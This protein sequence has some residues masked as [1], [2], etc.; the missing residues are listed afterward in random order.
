MLSA[1]GPW[2]SER[3]VGETE[4]FFEYALTLDEE[5]LHEARAQTDIVF[6]EMAQLEEQLAGEP[7][8]LDITMPDI[9]GLQA[10]KEIRRL[11]PKASVAM[12][13]AMG[14]QSIVIEALKSG[15]KLW[16][17][18]NPR[19]RL[20]LLQKKRRQHSLPLPHLRRFRSLSNLPQC[21]K[22]RLPPQTPLR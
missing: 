14:Q 1:S 19:R 3:L 7:E 16:A 18:Q 13:T 8:L 20:L 10:L 4:L 5:V 2:A 11:D 15:A 17:A 9:D 22:P 21:S 12:V 6:E